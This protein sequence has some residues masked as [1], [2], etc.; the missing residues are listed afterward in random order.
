MGSGP[1]RELA[2]LARQQRAWLLTMMPMDWRTGEHGGG[3]L[4]LAGL[5]AAEVPV[6]LARS[7]SLGQFRRLRCGDAALID[8][9]LQRAAAI[10]TRPRCRGVAAASSAALALVRSEGWRRARLAEHVARFARRGTAGFTLGLSSTPIQPLLVG[11]ASAALALSA[12]CARPDSG[13][14]PSAA[15]VPAGSARLRI[16]L[17]A[18]TQS[19]Y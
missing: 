9:L 5:G 12:R 18:A 19:G 4:E 2:A 11:I 13:W 14:R 17:S 8:Y 16:T 3:V 1:V 7:A 10:S 6:L 15:D